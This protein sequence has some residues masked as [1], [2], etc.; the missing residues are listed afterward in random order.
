MTGLRYGLLGCG[1]IAKNHMSAAIDNGFQVQALCDIFPAA[2]ENVA[3]AHGLDGVAR[4][5]DYH[6]MLA[7]EP[8][9][10]VAVTTKSSL[11]AEAALA[12]IEAGVN[13]IIEKPMALSIADADAIIAAAE[14][15]GVK[16][17]ACH[18]NRYNKPIQLLR[19]ALE[20][21]HLGKP[22]YAHA[23]IR[24]SRDRAYY[25]QA[26]WR[27]T[28]AEDG[29]ALMNQCLHNIDL[30]R[31]M[32]GEDITEVF[33]Y[34]DQLVHDYI[35][36]EDFGIAL[37][38]FANGS[39]GLLEGTTSVYPDDFEETLTLFGSSG[40]AKIGGK[41]LNRLEHWQLADDDRGFEELQELVAEQP[42]DIYGFGHLPLYA[43]M[44][45]AI[46][47]GRQPYIDAQT[48][49]EAIE[50]VLAIYQSAAE[51]RPV[52]LPL[53]AVASTDFSGRF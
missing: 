10:L 48:G 44:A 53:G 43:D 47:D 20:G 8:L 5:T 18:Q 15:R 12:C 14:R 51:G 31:W 32:M 3:A 17:C 37:I 16:V 46:R 52:Q 41:S 35:E 36:A 11:H 24:W 33:A 45:A 6:E 28:W 2:M 39:Y 49:K 26:D 50:L 27:G 9:D 23:A 34:T 42:D 19:Q 22:L 30:L 4:Y 25:Q 40:T 7:A 1:R 38:K 29:G 13:V 21:G